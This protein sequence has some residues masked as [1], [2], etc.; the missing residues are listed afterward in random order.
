VFEHF[1]HLLSLPVKKPPDLF[2]WVGGYGFLLGFITLLQKTHKR[3][4]FCVS[5][6]SSIEMQ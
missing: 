1:L 6:F 4:P 3:R 2:V 5:S